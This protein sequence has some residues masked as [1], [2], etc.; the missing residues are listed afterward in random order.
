M[1]EEAESRLD[2]EIE[3]D[4]KSTNLVPVEVRVG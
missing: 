3:A 4:Q 1:E 2:D